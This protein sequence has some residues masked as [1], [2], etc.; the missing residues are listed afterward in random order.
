MN[1]RDIGLKV[2]EAR[3]S[4]GLTQSELALVAG[5][6]LRFIIELE[7]GKESCQ[8]QKVLQV[9]NTLNLTIHFHE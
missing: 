4:K 9:L 6:G 8:I 3:L 2:R 7:Q 1:I 5:V